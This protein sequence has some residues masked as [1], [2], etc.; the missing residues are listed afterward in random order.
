MSTNPYK[1]GRLEPS[2]R[3]HQ[4]HAALFEAAFK[5]ATGCAMSL[6]HESE[7]TVVDFGGGSVSQEELV[8][9]WAVSKGLIPAGY[10]ISPVY[11]LEPTPAEGTEVPLG[12]AQAL[13]ARWTEELRYMSLNLEALERAGN[14][15][16]L[17]NYYNPPEVLRDTLAGRIKALREALA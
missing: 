16:L 8:V 2:A 17:A 13:L 9:G 3:P 12:K 7:P 11:S 15:H 6:A 4:R 5:E 14:R 1:D 10:Y